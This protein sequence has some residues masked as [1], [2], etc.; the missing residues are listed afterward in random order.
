VSTPKVTLYT[1]DWCPYC[2][3]ARSLLVA[4]GVT[5]EEID[6]EATPGAYEAMTAKSGRTSVPQVFIGGQHVGGC[7]DL[8]ALEAAGRLDPLLKNA[9]CENEP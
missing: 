2:S 6:V 7:D 4:K 8:H 5:F 1:T 3:R 9:S